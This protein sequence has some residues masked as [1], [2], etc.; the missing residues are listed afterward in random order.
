[1][2][3]MRDV[4]TII[5]QGQKAQWTGSKESH[6]K[7]PGIDQLTEINYLFG[8]LSVEYPFFLPKADGD[9]S[10]K[11]KLWISLLQGSTRE[12]RGQALKV[13]FQHYT[14][15]GGPNVAQFK[16]LLHKDP[17]HSDYKAL[18]LPEAKQ[19]IVERELAKM[20]EILS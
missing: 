20:K 14:D 1:M 19:S 3:N 10:R 13:C 11:R 17:A 5:Q 15:K 7:P 9:L 18:P 4:T 6:T 8:L 12:E 16:K 2:T